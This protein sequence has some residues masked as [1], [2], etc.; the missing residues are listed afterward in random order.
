MTNKTEYAE[1]LKSIKEYAKYL[2]LAY[3][4]NNYKELIEEHN[5]LKTSITDFYEDLLQKETDIRYENGKQNRIRRANFPYKKHIEDLK[6]EYLPEDAQNKLSNLETLEFIKNGQNVILAGNPGTG[7]THIAIGLGIQACKEGFKVLFTSAPTLINKLK[8]SKSNRTLTTIQN[9]FENY[10]LII[11]DELGYISF[12]KEGGELLFTHL[13]LRAE[14]KSTIITTNL[15]FEK[16]EDIF[17][18]PVMT[19]AIIDRITHK[20]TVV[21]MNG[22]SYR[23]RETQAWI[24]KTKD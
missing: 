12:D 10:D 6:R 13:S 3:S 11:L 7:K 20:A 8:E 24:A 17:K 22:N 21:N 1:K 15:A 4:Y 19:A 16:W 2:K 14:R 18:D 23:L 5:T 9:Q